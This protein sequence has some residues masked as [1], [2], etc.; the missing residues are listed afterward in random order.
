MIK[1]KA[2]L[3]REP[4]WAGQFYPA[5][6]AKLV[7]AVKQYLDQGVK[8]QKNKAELNKLKQK[9]RLKALI[10]PHAGYIYSGLIMGAGYSLVQGLSYKKVLLLGPNHRV[11]FIGGA[12][13]D[14]DFWQTP[15]GKVKQERLGLADLPLFSVHNVAHKEE[16]SLEVQLPF[17][18]T[19]LSDFTIMPILLAQGFAYDLAQQALETILTDQNT[20][21][22]VS[23][24]L[25]HYLSYIEA[26]YVDR[27]TLSQIV[28]GQNVEPEQACGALAINFLQY[29][30]HIYHWRAS[31]VAYANS[32][33]TAGNKQEVVGYGA[34]AYWI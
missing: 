21:I 4:T 19:V 29:I 12:L 10:V 26:S 17:L 13:A 14:W 16:H 34:V 15:L 7:K 32:G 11:P 31:I 20:L 5:Q 23:S 3:I 33:D 18:Q 25:S 8:K 22:I 27:L 9:K 1:D 30:A 24:D 2:V 6:K 28:K